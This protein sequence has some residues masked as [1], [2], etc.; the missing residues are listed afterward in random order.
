MYDKSSRFENIFYWISSST[1]LFVISVYGVRYCFGSLSG[2]SINHEVYLLLCQV[3]AIILYTYVYQM[4]A[5]PPEGFDAEEDLPLKN[6]PEDVAPEQVP[7]LT[8][9]SPKEISPPQVRLPVQNPEP[10]GRGDS[11]KNKV[12]M[13]LWILIL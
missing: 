4:F 7:L 8:Q 1:L 12:K 6:L 10:R 2:T 9:N 5:P 11:R 13:Q 3:G